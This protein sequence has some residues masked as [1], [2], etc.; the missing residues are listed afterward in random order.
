MVA[1]ARVPVRVRVDAAR[2]RPNDLPSLL[3][4]SSRIRY[5]LGWTPMIPLSQTLD[6][7]VEYWRSVEGK[8]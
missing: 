6:D 4:D 8:K 2:Y 7:L 1:R 3:G 5:E